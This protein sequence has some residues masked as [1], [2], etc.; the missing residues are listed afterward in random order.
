M[1]ALANLKLSENFGQNL[2]GAR[3]VQG[4][5]ILSRRA[6]ISCYALR[7]EVER[8]ASGCG[9]C[10]IRAFGESELLQRGLWP[11]RCA[12]ALQVIEASLVDLGDGMR[13]RVVARSSKF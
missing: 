13:Y 4:I 11:P 6:S 8:V 3:F 5:A 1:K 12:L 2:T 7:A 10:E 9:R